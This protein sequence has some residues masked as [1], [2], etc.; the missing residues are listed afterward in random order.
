MQ[1]FDNNVENIYNYIK[2]ENHFSTFYKNSDETSI[3]QYF[4]KYI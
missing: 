2:E 1:R 3:L 4:K